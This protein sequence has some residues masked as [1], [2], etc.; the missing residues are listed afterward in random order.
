MARLVASVTVLVTL[1]LGAASAQTLNWGNA[2]LDV[3]IDSAGNSLTDATYTFELGTFSSGFVPTEFNTGQWAREWLVLDSAIY[4]D[5][6]GLFISSYTVTAEDASLAGEQAYIWVYNNTLGDETS[7]W[8]IITDDS[9][10][11]GI[12]DEWVVPSFAEPGAGSPPANFDWRAATATTPVWGGLNGVAGSGVQEVAPS[13]FDLQTFTFSAI[14]PE[15]S[16]AV[17]LGIAS[18]GLLRRRRR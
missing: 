18:L 15:P 7:E 11:D 14:V 13:A 6:V 17:L 12:G 3:N 4:N 10:D 1:A 16:S 5:S 8:V 2:V 9:P